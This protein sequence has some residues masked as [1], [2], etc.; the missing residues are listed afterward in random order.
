ML[1]QDIS[2]ESWCNAPVM[3]W[4]PL[5]EWR[6]CRVPDAQVLR[7]RFLLQQ[8]RLLHRL[9]EL[10]YIRRTKNIKFF[11]RAH[12][13]ALTVLTPR[14]LTCFILR[15]L[16]TRLLDRRHTSHVL[17]ICSVSYAPRTLQYSKSSSTPFPPCPATTCCALYISTT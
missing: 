11:H 12:E 13:H 1:L 14:L 16:A 5:P 8:P 7:I 9:I 2:Y 3:T 6:C 4:R 17:Y 15:H 10:C